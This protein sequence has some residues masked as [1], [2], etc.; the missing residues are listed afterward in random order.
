MPKDPKTE[1]KE[2]VDRIVASQSRKKLVV[3]GPGA[4]KTYLFRK[5]LDVAP[6]ERHQRLVLTFINTLKN[7]LTNNLGDASE[8]SRCMDIANIFFIN[9]RSC[10]MAYLKSSAAIRDS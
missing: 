3:A 10:E 6:G 9:M 4:G 5:L 7:D 2:A 8:V 1:A